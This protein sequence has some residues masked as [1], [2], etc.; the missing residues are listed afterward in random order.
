MVQIPKGIV[1]SCSGTKISSSEFD[2]FSKIDPFGFILFTR[3]FK[4][5]KQISE[6]IKNL[7]NISLNKNLQIFVDH[8]GG[9]VQRFNN[10][11]FFSIPSQKYF[12]DIYKK[13]CDKAKNL[14]FL[15][16]R[17]M[18]FELK[19]I[20]ID[21]NCSPVLDIFFDFGDNIIGDRSFSEDPEIVSNLAKIYCEGMR[22]SGIFPVL[23]H[24]PGHGRSDK[25]SHKTLPEIKVNLNELKKIDLKPYVR[26]KNENF[27][28]LAHILY[29]NL[30][31]K[32]APYSKIIIK[33]ILKDIILYKGFTLSDDLDMKAL[34]GDIKL[35][36]KNCYNGGC[37]I[38]LYC[39]G[40][41]SDMKKIYSVSKLVCK[42][43]FE[44]FLKS[45]LHIKKSKLSKKYLKQQIDRINIID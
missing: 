1:L 4:S 8:E 14:A 18:G 32:V 44:F 5:K 21:I 9:R 28:M 29:S 6:L 22:E 39:S 38:L 11:E 23:K 42:N 25:D 27:L 26:L 16:S 45:K 36:A 19:E 30:D 35:K 10:E 41:L 31:K 24:F 7:K 2:F 40:V 33:N 34:N 43:K 12:G 37:D 17:L 3:N 15:Y 13:N 20:G